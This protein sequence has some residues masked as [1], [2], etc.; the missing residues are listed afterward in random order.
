MTNEPIDDAVERVA[1]A[2]HPFLFPVELQDWDIQAKNRQTTLEATRVAIAA[3]PSS[4]REKRL[5][6][7]LRIIAGEKQCVDNLMSHVDIARAALAKEIAHE[8]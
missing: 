4:T 3:M 2:L 6:D 1:D 5:E 8:F 7:A